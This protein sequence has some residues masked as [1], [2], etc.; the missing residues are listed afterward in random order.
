MGGPVSS[1]DLLFPGAVGKQAREHDRFDV[2]WVVLSACN[3]S[4][5]GAGSETEPGLDRTS[6]FA[7]APKAKDDSL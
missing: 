4:G 3:T 7:G 2:D 5:G 1:A 6:F